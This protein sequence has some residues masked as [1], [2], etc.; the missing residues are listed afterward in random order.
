MD[1]WS[2]LKP[3]PQRMFPL[4]TEEGNIFWR[5][6][7]AETKLEIHKKLFAKHLLWYDE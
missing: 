6:N 7:R 2:H 1:F 4:H 3:S 5:W